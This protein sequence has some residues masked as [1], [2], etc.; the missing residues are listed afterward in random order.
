[1]RARGPFNSG[2]YWYKIFTSTL[3]TVG[4]HGPYASPLFMREALNKK[5]K[6]PFGHVLEKVKCNVHPM[7]MGMK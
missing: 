7:N 6:E 1:M 4:P 2:R 5:K 3:V